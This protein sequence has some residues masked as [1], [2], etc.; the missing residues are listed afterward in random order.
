[1]VEREFF[2]KFCVVGVSYSEW[3]DN[4]SRKT[5][6]VWVCDEDGQEAQTSKL[7]AQNKSPAGMKVKWHEEENVQ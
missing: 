2:L 3:S 6:S 1:M 5:V 4:A 7:K